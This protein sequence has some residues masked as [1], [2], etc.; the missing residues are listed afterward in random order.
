MKGKEKSRIGKE[1]CILDK[2]GMKREF[3]GRLAVD[4]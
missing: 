4:W 1:N 2:E 3:D